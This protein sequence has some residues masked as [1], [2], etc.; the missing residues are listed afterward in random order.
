M[1]IL[2][3]SM[4]LDVH[5]ICTQTASCFCST[6]PP[7]SSF[8]ITNP[9]EILWPAARLTS[10]RP[11]LVREVLWPP[12]RLKSTLRLSLGGG[13][14]HKWDNGHM[15]QFDQAQE[16]NAILINGVCSEKENIQ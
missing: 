15:G 13:E 14:F 7:S 1:V 9:W 5:V 8:L 10:S 6:A 2:L 11:S 3:L 4:R 16:T 12:A